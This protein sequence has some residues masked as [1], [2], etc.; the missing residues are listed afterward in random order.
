MLIMVG[1]MGITSYVPTYIQIVYGMGATVSGYVMVP[2]L[3]GV[4][5]ASSA[6]GF[7]SSR[8]TRVKLLPFAGC[9]L[10]A[11]GSALFLSLTVDS[12]VWLV[13][14]FLCL[15]G[16]GIGMGQQIV[17]LMSQ[18]EFSIEIVG[19]ATSANNF[20]REIGATVGSTIIGSLFT[21]NLMA[22]L[23]ACTVDG[24]SLESL[25][26]V[27]DSITPSLVSGLDAATQTAVRQA[28]NEALIPIFAELLVMFLIAAVVIVRTR[29][30]PLAT[31]NADSGRQNRR[32]TTTESA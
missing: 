27:A 4:M 24:R 20:F 3:L 32:G 14:G 28:Y 31:T 26:I 25:G 10:G 21:S 22:N 12:S 18:N 8:I 29:T 16:I 19:T 13:C 2:M 15:I 6:T 7:L 1:M 30:V 17:V 9:L 5:G 11:L 23:S